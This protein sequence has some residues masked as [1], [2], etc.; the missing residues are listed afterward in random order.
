[1]SPAE[2]CPL[3]NS[4][5]LWEQPR[6]FDLGLILNCAIADAIEPGDVG[7]L[8]LQHAGLW[9]CDLGNEGLIWSGGVYDI[10]GLQRGSTINRME[11]LSLYCED[12]RSKMERLRT[13]AIRHR[14]GFTIDIDVRAAAVGELRR[15]RLIAAPV[16]EGQRVVRLHGIKLIV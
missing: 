6:H 7:A 8:G 15:V 11:A 4:W 3:H 14:R 10:F 16:C 2:P 1:M 12:S 5:P 9:E 13:Y